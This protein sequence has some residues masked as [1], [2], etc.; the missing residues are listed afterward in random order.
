[1]LKEPIPSNT[2]DTRGKVNYL[3]LRR[4]CHHITVAERRKQYN[5]VRILHYP[6]SVDTVDSIADPQN[7]IIEWIIREDLLERKQELLLSLSEQESRVYKTVY[8]DGETIA[9]TARHLNL[10]N[11]TVRGTL[12]RIRRKNREAAL[13]TFSRRVYTNKVDTRLLNEPEGS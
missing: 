1:M 7:G 6:V 4:T 9:E 13:D 10:K 5:R 11:N 3:W 12:E 8:Q 2:E